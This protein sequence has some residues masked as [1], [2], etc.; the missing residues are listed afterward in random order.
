MAMKFLAP[1]KYLMG[2]N[3]EVAE[4]KYSVP[5]LRSDPLCDQV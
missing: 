3:I 5:L 4:Y 1:I 2:H